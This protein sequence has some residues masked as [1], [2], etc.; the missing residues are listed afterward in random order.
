M[1]QGPVDRTLRAFGQRLMSSPEGVL[2][3]LAGPPRRNDRGEALDLHTQLLLRLEHLAGEGLNVDA[4]AE[5]RAQFQR[6]V[7]L[8]AGE[9][10]PV[11]VLDESLPG[12]H[13]PVPVRHY[14]P[15]GHE[16]P[17]LVYFHGGGW[18]VGDVASYDPVCRRLA[19]DADLHV[20]SVDY[21]LAPEHPF[22]Q[23]FDDALAVV[24][25]LLARHGAVAVGGD[26]AGGHLSALLAQRRELTAQILVYPATDLRRLTDSHRT[27]AT[28]YL[29]ESEAIDRYL[30][31]F[32]ADPTDPAASPALASPG[33]APAVVVTAGFDPLRDEG[34]AYVD[35]LRAHGVPV[36]H[37]AFPGMV[38]G[39]YN[40]DGLL[41]SAD[42]AVAKINEVVRYVCRGRDTV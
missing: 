9:P 2:R 37:L 30:A 35:A 13:G 14:L 19:T 40:M 27:L 17:V 20:V 12:P 15:V 24:D 7:A 3:R 6:S 5:A 22:P 39:F 42:R 29:L 18:A 1:P 16:L 32:R 36:E 8:V 41:P 38:H 26:S 4:P 25:A 34:E 31:W 11:T 21:R 33:G 10:L 23:G 28:G